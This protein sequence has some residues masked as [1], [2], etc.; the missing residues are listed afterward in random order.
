MTRWLTG[1]LLFCASLVAAAC[2]LCIG[3]YRQSPAQ[4]L[5]TLQQAVL[6][7]P[8]ADRSSYRV[9]EVIKGERPPNDLID[10]GSYQG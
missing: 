5:A 10:E 9:V 3:A 1:A 7:I 2:P 6:A 4:E 8:S